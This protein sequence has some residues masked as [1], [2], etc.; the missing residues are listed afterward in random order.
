MPSRQISNDCIALGFY[1][2][3]GDPDGVKSFY[4]D[5]LAWF[6]AVKCPPDKLSV[7]GSGFG[8]KPVNFTKIHARLSKQGFANVK[9][10]ALVAMLPDGTI[11][12]LDWW[13]IA[14]IDL[15]VG[16]RPCFCLSARASVASLEDDALTRLT[17]SC[18]SNLKPAYGIGFHRNHDLG[19]W[20]YAVGVNYASPTQESP[21]D[22]DEALTIFRWGDFAD[23]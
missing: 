21:I 16:L 18:L 8:G 14:S 20:F 12:T 11:P 3:A 1:G 15:G 2:V 4:N 9:G 5:V 6:D 7:H 13:A 17:T 10:F 23:V 19:P 22:Y